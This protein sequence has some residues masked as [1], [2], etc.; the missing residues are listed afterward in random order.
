MVQERQSQGKGVC[1]TLRLWS[2]AVIS[3]LLLSTCFIASCVD[4]VFLCN[5]PWLSW[6]SL[7]RSG[8][9]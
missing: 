4:R 7:H 1:W 8:W 9:P 6:N 3:M 2:A 5:K